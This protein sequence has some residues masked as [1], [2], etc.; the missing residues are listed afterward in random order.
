MK[1]LIA[2]GYDTQNLGDYASFLGLYKVL[3]KHEPKAK[4]SVLSRHPDDMFSRQF[5]VETIMNLDHS[6][7]AKSL[8]RFFFGFNEDDA[9]K[10][11]LRIAEKMKEADCLL[12]GNGRLFVDISIGYMR[13]PLNYFAVLIQLAKFLNKPIILNSVSFVEPSTSM[14]KEVLKFIIQN[15]S[16]IIVREK[17]SAKIA[18]QYT[19]NSSKIK[20]LPDIAFAL[21]KIDADQTNIPEVF[22]DSIGI[23]FRGINYMQ[24]IDNNFVK[25]NTK[26]IIE[27]LDSTSKNVVFCHQCTYDIDDNLTDDRYANRLI[28]NELPSNYKKRC[29]IFDDK[30]TLAQTLGQYSK[31]SH[32]FTERRHGFIMSLT[33][34]T[35]STLVCLEENTKIVEETITEKSLF[36]EN[37]DSFLLTKSFPLEIKSTIENLRSQMDNYYYIIKDIVWENNFAR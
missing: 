33:Q 24:E 16:Q 21:S 5:D 26:K 7:R 12:I 31:L 19:H 32:L 11:L 23:N 22:T 18:K 27:L 4:F 37:S 15:A 20:V 3:N 2:G 17:S 13:G 10:N 34:G 1:I 30:W 28:F 36:I 25:H 29:Y 35:P 6:S 9:N 14:G 8:G